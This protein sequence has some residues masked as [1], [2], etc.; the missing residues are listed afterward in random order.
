MT[1]R[2]DPHERPQLPLKVERL[3]YEYVDGT[4][5]VA[6]FMGRVGAAWDNVQSTL[7]MGRWMPGQDVR[8]D[9]SHSHLSEEPS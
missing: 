8:A 3:T 2:L 4:V 9:I 6:F 7:N 5:H 1:Y